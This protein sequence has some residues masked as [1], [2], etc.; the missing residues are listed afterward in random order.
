MQFLTLFWMHSVYTSIFLRIIYVGLV[1]HST[2]VAIVSVSTIWEYLAASG[3]T[4]A[5]I[6]A[7]SEYSHSTINGTPTFSSFG[8]TML[9]ETDITDQ[10]EFWMCS[11]WLDSDSVVTWK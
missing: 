8:G 11:Q 2:T 10:E 3:C 7:A 5:P 6:T 1:L 9:H 4:A